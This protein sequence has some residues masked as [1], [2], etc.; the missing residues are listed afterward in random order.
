MRDIWVVD[1]D[2]EMSR[3]VGLML[4]LLDCNVTTM[5]YQQLER[6]DRRKYHRKNQHD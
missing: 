2:E 1:D 4:G 5:N 3:A 6:A